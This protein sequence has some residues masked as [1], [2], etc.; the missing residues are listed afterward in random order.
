VVAGEGGRDSKNFVHELTDIYVR[1]AAAKRLSTELLSDE[2]GHTVLKVTGEA[3]G[4]TF[5]HEPG[6]H[7]VQR[8]PVTE[9]SGRRQT[10]L[11]SVAVLPMP[12][13]SEYRPL[14][15]NEI[16]W[17]AQTGRQSAGGQNVNKVASAVRMTHVPTG[18]SVFINGRD[19]GQ[20]RKQAHEILSAR[21][22]DMKRRLATEG[23]DR[24]RREVLS[25]TGRGDK[26]RTWN[27]IE[28]RIAD[29]RLGTKTRNVKEVLKGRLDL[30]LAA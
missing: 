23:Y 30:I 29:H 1:Y 13:R 21:V 19:Q 18:L 5:R 26:V 15:E 25:D 3:A 14:P 7:S 20:N 10:S 4:Q 11:V 28:G 6:K 2:D 24:I 17:K 16:E 12:P 22:H 9:S 27:F 8:V